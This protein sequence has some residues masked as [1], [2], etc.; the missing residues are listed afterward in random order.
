[1]S[2]QANAS[3]LQ[4]FNASTLIL[5]AVVTILA[6]LLYF[7]SAARDIVV[8]DTPELI[9]AAATLGVAH[10]PGYPLFTMLGHLFSVMPIGPTPFRVNLL[11]V[12]C[13]AL[14]VGVVFLTAL[15]LTQSRLA[16]A[17]AALILAAV[18]NFWT[19]SLVAEV[20]PLNNLLASVL[21]YFL[22]TWHE[23]LQRRS[24]LIAAFFVTGL[25]LTNHHTII[26]LAPA[27]CFVLWRQR[28][29]FLTRPG[30]LAIGI[31]AFCIWLLP[32]GYVLWAS[33]HH[34]A[35]NWGNVSSF[36]DLVSLIARKSYGS[37]RLVGMSS[38]MGGSPFARIL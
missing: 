12:T 18:P 15:R 35:W 29:V 3:T 21:I 36:R 2:T 33:V 28:T 32:C 11:A 30:L 6:G 16:A 20:F 1:M 13:D 25:S 14:T 31:A 34:P 8:G 22:V 19:W 37:H 5:A 24:V 17:T 26:L 10:P 4:R 27:F 38:Y 23:E 7:L 9:T